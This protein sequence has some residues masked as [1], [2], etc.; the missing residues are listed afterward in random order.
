MLEGPVVGL[1]VGCMDGLVVVGPAEGGCD[2]CAEGRNEGTKEG[3]VDG[4]IDG[5]RVTMTEGE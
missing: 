4:L 5:L 2:G 3:F 1:R